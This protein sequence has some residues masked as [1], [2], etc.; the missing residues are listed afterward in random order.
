[1]PDTI[2]AF[3]SLESPHHVVFETKDG[4]LSY[5]L[6]GVLVGELEGSGQK[7][8]RF[9][10]NFGVPIPGLPSGKG[11][12]LVHWA[13]VATLNSIANDS[14]AVDAGWAVD[15][16]RLLDTTAVRNS[17][18]LACDLAVRDADG[19]VLRVGFSI[20]LLGSVADLRS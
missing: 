15:G 4:L 6:T 17:V 14:T 8:L 1:M 5:T 13:P 19:F 16:F 20:H 9:T 18:D 7:W 10:M 11:L 12:K 3:T 2:N